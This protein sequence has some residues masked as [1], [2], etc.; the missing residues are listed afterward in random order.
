MNFNVWAVLIAFSGNL[1]VAQEVDFGL[2][3]TADLIVEL[4]YLKQ[5]RPEFELTDEYLEDTVILLSE[6]AF[7]TG[8]SEAI[9][10]SLINT[11][12]FEWWQATGTIVSDE[13]TSGVWEDAQDATCVDDPERIQLGRVVLK[14]LDVAGH[15]AREIQRRETEIFIRFYGDRLRPE[16]VTG[17][18]NGI[19]RLLQEWALD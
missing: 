18:L 16:V 12:T 15:V 1:A 6:M 17:P 5:D 4:E 10:D 19:D 14:R 2:K 3:S 11:F 7:C 8:R 9:S 13:M